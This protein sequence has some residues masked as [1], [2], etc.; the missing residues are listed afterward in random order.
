M[1]KLKPCPFCGGAAKLKEVTI[2]STMSAY[3]VRCG[4]VDCGVRPSTSYF[5][6]K[7]EAI[8]RWNRRAE[9]GK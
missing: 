1:D 9:D 4:D 2:G 8:K 6:L 7:K 5:R 3:I